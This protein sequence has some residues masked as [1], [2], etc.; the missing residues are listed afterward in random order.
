MDYSI[1]FW[2]R[3]AEKYAKKPVA[4]EAT[5]Q[6]KLDVTKSYLQLHMK[7]LE[8][9]CGTGSTALALA[10]YVREYEAIDVS[11]KMIAITQQ[12]LAVKPIPNLTF[13][14]TPLEEYPV[15]E[16]SL[17]V[18]LGHSIL[19]LLNDPEATIQRVYQML[20]PGGIFISSTACLADGMVILRIIAPL[21]KWLRLIPPVRVFSRVELEASLSS[22]GFRIDYRLVHDKNRMSCFLVAVKPESH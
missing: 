17:D 19:H 18:V 3:I 5:Y 10:P 6:K 16:G 20:K 14:Q 2:D 7:A 12:K 9:G 11:P 1:K 22:T 13:K 8:F 15:P 21:G 4:D